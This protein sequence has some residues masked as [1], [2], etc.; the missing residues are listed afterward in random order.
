MKRVEKHYMSILGLVLALVVILSAEARADLYTFDDWGY[1]GGTA[2]YEANTTVMGQLSIAVT[3][4]D[5][6]D[7]ETLLAEVGDHQ[8]LFI[9]SKS[10]TYDASLTDIYFEDGALLGIAE[11]FNNLTTGVIFASPI[12]GQETLPNGNNATPPF[13]TTQGFSADSK[14]TGSGVD[15]SGESVGILFN[16]DQIP[17]SENYYTLADVI[18]A[19]Y[20]GFDDP[21]EEL[22]LRIGIHVRSI[23]EGSGYSQSYI[24]TPVP[25]AVILGLLGLGAVGLKLRKFA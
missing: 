25:G 5:V 7:G 11:V 1:L 2:G 22:S 13:E 19:I 16:L 8:V 18:A 24:L 14:N 4:E 12:N 10:G 9:F 3:D 23:G 6:Y 15:I 21:T 17:E 20:Q